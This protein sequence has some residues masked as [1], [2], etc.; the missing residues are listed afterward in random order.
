MISKALREAFFLVSY[1]KK[2]IEENKFSLYP[3]SIFFLK[4]CLLKLFS[5]KSFFK[6]N[7]YLKLKEE[8]FFNK[9]LLSKKHFQM[10]D[11]LSS[12]KPL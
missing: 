1:Q 7:A 5:D 2:L 3:R 11:Y 9:K 6:T 8:I 4:D 10:K 12:L